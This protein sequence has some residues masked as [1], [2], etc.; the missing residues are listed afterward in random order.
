VL[1]DPMR[2]ASGPG[3]ENYFLT[4]EH[5]A[6]E[7]RFPYNVSPLAFLEYDEDR[8]V[9]RIRELGW[10]KPEDTDPNSTNCLLNAFANSIHR[11][12]FNYNPYAF[13]LA[14]LVREG[15][16][17]RLEA[18]SRLEKEEDPEMIRFVRERLELD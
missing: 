1:F 6:L 3:L 5:L 13:E 15:Y 18:I 12:R 7:D 17:D 10:R 14:K 11:E 2:E 8:I 16:M 4:E 9:E